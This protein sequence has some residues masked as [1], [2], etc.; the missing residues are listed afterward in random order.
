MIITCKSCGTRYEINEDLVKPEG[1]KVRC[2]RCDTV[3]SAY[4]QEGSEPAPVEEESAGAMESGEEPGERELPDAAGEPAGEPATESAGEPDQEG[5]STT[6]VFESG[7]EGLIDEFDTDASFEEPPRQGT[8]EIGMESLEKTTFVDLRDL[9]PTG[10]AAPEAGDGEKAGEEG[11]QEPTRG[12][13]TDFGLETMTEDELGIDQNLEDF[14]LDLVDEDE[15]ATDAGPSAKTDEETADEEIL[16][17]TR[18]QAEVAEAADIEIEDIDEDFE[19]D[20]DDES[21]AGDRDYEIDLI[22]EDP[23]DSAEIG[24]PGIA[25]VEGEDL[26]MAVEEDLAAGDADEDIA[27]ELD[28]DLEEDLESQ[29]TL[30]FDLEAADPVTGGEPDAGGTEA[31]DFAADFELDFDLE[32]ADDTARGTAAPVEEDEFD[33]TDVEEFLDLEESTRQEDSGADD[34]ETFNLGL[35]TDAD[36]SSTAAAEQKEFDID[37]ETVGSETGAPATEDAGEKMAMETAMESPEAAPGE[38]GAA[39][40]RKEPKR[41]GKD[42]G[43]PGR[44]AGPGADKDEDTHTPAGPVPPPTRRRGSPAR[45]VFLVVLLFAAIAGGG[46]YYMA[47]MRQPAPPEPIAVA[48]DPEPEPAAELSPADPEGNLEIAISSPDYRFVS[49]V[50]AGEI[51]VASGSV[52]NRYDHPRREILVQGNLYGPEGER[53]DSSSPMFAGILFETEELEVLSLSEME[54]T[55]TA[56]GAMVRQSPV[57]PGQEMPFMVVFPQVPPDAVEMDVEVVS[58]TAGDD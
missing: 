6:T 55:L 56:P 54:S 28:F 31:E 7:V 41:S 15:P 3:F 5:T 43:S 32:E 26:T 2:T 58:S 50:D 19:V 9:E 17:M 20:F 44:E 39:W 23:V 57:E 36:T 1:S 14:N 47:E 24:E 53:I 33:L 22:E 49:N 21:E 35:E 40:A 34:E 30:D 45:K 48:P 46:Y 8:R 16:D 27:V 42:T 11:G 37:M 52:T 12:E 25:P 4:R 10:Q 18:D 51:L 38:Q 29:E 13:V